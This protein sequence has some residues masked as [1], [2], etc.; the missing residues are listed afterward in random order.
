MFTFDIFDTNADGI[1]D[2]KQV[3]TMFHDL[4]GNRA[5]ESERIK[6]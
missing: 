5:E 6:M 1:L 3:I 4:T 2:A